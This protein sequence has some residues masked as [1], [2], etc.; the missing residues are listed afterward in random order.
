MTQI[1]F[2]AAGSLTLVNTTPLI[3]DRDRLMI[4]LV[5]T[6]GAVLEDLRIDAAAIH[7]APMAAIMQA[8]TVTWTDTD[9]VVQNGITF[10]AWPS[11]TTPIGQTGT[12]RINV[13]ADN[14]GAFNIYVKGGAGTLYVN[15]L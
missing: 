13:K 12:I 5:F 6:G 3:P 15:A 10:M 9:I 8:T 11:G 14:H 2:L 1:A 4:E 7:T